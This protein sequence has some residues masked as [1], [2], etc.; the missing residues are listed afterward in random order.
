MTHV[1]MSRTA[2]GTPPGWGPAKRKKIAARDT[3][4]LEATIASKSLALS[5]LGPRSAAAKKKFRQQIG[6]AKQL[7]EQTQ[8][9]RHELKLATM[10]AADRKRVNNIN[11]LAAESGL[12]QVLLGQKTGGAS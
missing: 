8:R 6:D 5:K 11:R 7:L 1:T 10:T 3:K 4:A 12:P 2:D 9:A